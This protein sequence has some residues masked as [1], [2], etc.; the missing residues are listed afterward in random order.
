VLPA[1]N[2][3]ALRNV[4]TGG[5]GSTIDKSVTVQLETIEASPGSCPVGAASDPTTVNLFIEDDDGDVVFDGSGEGFVCTI[6]VK[7]QANFEVRFQGPE[8][9]QGSAVPSGQ[10]FD[11]DLFVNANTEHGSLDEIKK[12]RCSR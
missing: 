10:F 6:G 5:A 3:A 7:L 8:N 4:E 1:G 12:N 9:C 2:F 11:G